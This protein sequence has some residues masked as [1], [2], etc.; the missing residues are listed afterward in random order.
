MIMSLKDVA[1]Q[2]D[3]PLLIKQ[4]QHLHMLAALARKN[5][6]HQNLIDGV[7]NFI[8]AFQDAAIADGV[9][10]AEDVFGEFK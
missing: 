4:K 7:L 1:A 2:T 3:W 10:T 6:E 8:D 9:V 5:P